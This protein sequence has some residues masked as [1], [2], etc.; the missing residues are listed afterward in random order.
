GAA[1]LRFGEEREAVPIRSRCGLRPRG[2]AFRRRDEGHGETGGTRELD[3]E[4]GARKEAFEGA[5][6]AC[7]RHGVLAGKCGTAE[8]A[9]QASRGELPAL[10]EVAAEGSLVAG[11]VRSRG[12]GRPR[13]VPLQLPV[14]GKGAGQREP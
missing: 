4:A 5:G 13:I 2:A 9:L 10:T 3:A 6:G 8:D 11:L 1:K 12:R 7:Q 14:T